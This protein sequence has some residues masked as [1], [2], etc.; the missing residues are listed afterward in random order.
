MAKMLDLEKGFKKYYQYVQ[1]H[2]EDGHNVY[3]RKKSSKRIT[4]DKKK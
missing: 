1:G 2:E 3:V 4:N